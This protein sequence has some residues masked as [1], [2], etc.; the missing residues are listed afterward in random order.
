MSF[1]KKKNLQKSDEFCKFSK[2]KDYTGSLSGAGHVSLFRAVCYIAF[3]S[4][5]G[6]AVLTSCSI[7]YT[8]PSVAES[9]KPEFIFNNASFSR[10]EGGS[11]K[12]V[13]Y[14]GVIEL[15]RGEDSMY[16][17]DLSFIV[18]GSK[19]DLSVTGSCGLMAAD[20]TNESYSFF[21]DV[22]ITSYEQNLR[23]EADNVR[24]DGK[25]GQLVS[26]G[27]APVRVYSGGFSNESSSSVTAELTG[28]GF[29]ADGERL[30]YVFSEGVSG[31]IYTQDSGGGQ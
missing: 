21:D 10:S 30:E 18:Y 16:G 20:T 8:V 14:A 6:V 7:D 3:F 26:A 17:K 13:L 24:W 1:F 22:S 29:S 31:T 19:G 2:I 27:V 11:I 4:I 15:Y 28:M 12:A 23:V 9:D 5:F 25:T